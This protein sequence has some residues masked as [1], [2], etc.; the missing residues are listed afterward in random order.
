MHYCWLCVRENVLC[1]CV[2]KNNTRSTKTIWVPIVCYTNLHPIQLRTS[3]QGRWALLCYRGVSNARSEVHVTM[4]VK[5]TVDSRFIETNIVVF[6]KTSCQVFLLQSSNSLTKD[7][8]MEI[9]SYYRKTK[10]IG[11]IRGMVGP[12]SKY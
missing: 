7:V 5:I 8:P 6:V 10:R 11:M 2:E 1:C 4:Q 9:T 3:T 12:T